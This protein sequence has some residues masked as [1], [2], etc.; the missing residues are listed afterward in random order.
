[1]ESLS[2]QVVAAAKLPIL[3]PNEFVRGTLLIALPDKHQLKFNIHKDAKSLMEAIEKR[4]GGNKEIKKVQKALLKQ[5]YENFTGSSSKSLDQIPD[6]I[7]KFISQMEILGESLSQEDL[8]DQSLDDLFTN[9]KIYEAEVKSSSSTS[10]ITQ[11]INFVSSH[12]TDSTNESSNSPQLHND[13]LKQIDALDLEEIYLKWQMAMLTMRARRVPG[14]IR[15]DDLFTNL[16]I[17]EA[18]VKSSSSTSHTTQNIDFVSSHN[19]DNSNESVSAV[20]SVFAASSKTLVFNILNVDNLSDAVIYSFFASQSNSPQLHNDD[21]KQID[22]DDLKEMDLKWQMAMLTIRARRFL[23]RTR[24]NI[25][26]NGTTSIGFDMSKVECYNCHRKGH[27]ARE[28]RNPRDTRNKDTQRRNIPVETTTSNALVSQCDGVGSYDWSFQADKELTNYVLMAF[29]STSSSSSDNKTSSKN[30]SN[31]LESQITD[32]TGLGY[33]NHVFNSTMFDCVELI[34]S[35]SDEGVPTSPVHDRYKSGAGYHAVPPLYTGTFMPSKPDLVF[36]DAPTASETVSTMFHVEPST[37]KLNKNFSQKSVELVGHPTPAEKLRKDILKSREYVAFGG[38]SKGGKITGKDPLGKFDEK[39][40]EGFL[41][42]YSSMNYQ[43][44]VAGNQPNSSVGIQ[45]N[46]DADPQNT[47]ANVAFDVK[48]NESEVHVSP[49]SSAK[50]K[51]HDEKEKK[52]AKGKSPVELSTRFRDLRDEFE[53]FLLTAQTGTP[54]TA[55]GRNSTNG[56]NNFNAASTPVTAVGPDSTNNTNSFSAAGPSN[57]AISPT[58]KISGKSLFVDPSQ[59]PDDLDMPTLKEIIYSDDEEEVKAEADFSNLET[60]ITI[61]PIPT[62]IVHKDHPVI[63]IIDD[64][65]SAPQTRCMTRVGHNREEGIDYKEVFASVARIEAIW[66][67]LAYA[68]FMGFMV[69]QMDVKSAFLYGTIEEEVY[70]CQPPGFED[71]DYPDKVYKV[72]KALY[73]LHQ[74]PRAWYETL[75]NYL[76]DN[77]F[78]REKID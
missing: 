5:Q 44:V 34:S 56:P 74:P 1:M 64:L 53:A 11:N 52:E 12:N 70:I 59:Y 37:T 46:L 16:K 47:D 65:S 50:P 76:L 36:H 41:V 62:T 19:T 71:L 60:S 24:R 57:I 43:P 15:Q 67:F 40:D 68:S 35:E 4:F 48:E 30:L 32:K 55:A 13:D 27:F 9:L 66:L 17:Y 33:D 39:A 54:V 61:S 18:E 8:E 29:T 78:Q 23:Q 73:G 51:Q 72:V 14:E 42:G 38:N 49:S 7:Q 20:A 31:L 26:A 21:L 6:R 77:G 22:A 25:G 2:P 28:C 45:E 63:Q 3:N 10:H 58:F 75:A 69:Y